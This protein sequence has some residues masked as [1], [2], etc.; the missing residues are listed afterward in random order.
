MVVEAAPAAPLEVPEAALLLD[1]LIIALDTPAQLGKPD[2][3]S[4]AD[5][6][7]Q[8]R[9]PIFGGRGF[10][11]GPLDEQTLRR[12]QF[13]QQVRGGGTTAPARK[14]RGEPIGRAF[15]PADRAPGLFR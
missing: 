2:Q 1:V 15:A 12:Y 3:R 4:E 5:I 9:E 11:L 14:P 7:R 10:P 8:G 13:R 6:L